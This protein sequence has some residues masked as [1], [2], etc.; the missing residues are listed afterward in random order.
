MRRSFLILALAGALLCSEA[1]A[2]EPEAGAA[3]VR[4]VDVGAGLCC[5]LVLPDDHYIVYDT[6][7]FIDGGETAMAAVE[8]LIPEDEEIDLLVLSHSDADHLAAADEILQAYTVRRVLR[9]GF[10]RNTLAW[11]NAD[12]AARAARYSDE[13]IDINLAYFEYPPGG[14][15]RFGEAFVTFIAGFHTP[16]EDWDIDGNSERRNAGSIVIRLQF[17]GRSALFTG[18]A[19]GRHI[20]G[21]DD[22]LIASERFMVEMSPI[23]GIDSD[24][25]I[26][27]H[28]GADN[29]SAAAF[30]EAVSPE[31]VIFSAG[32]RHEHPRASAAQRYLDFGVPVENIFR[33]DLG[34]DEGGA[35]WPAGRVAG[36]NDPR[37]DDDVDVLIRPDGEII[38]A[39]RDP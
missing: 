23:I 19:V 6:G 7:N 32:H 14:T 21:P 5:V 18:D 12:A 27:P 13:T 30:I 35:E 16:P 1:L 26:A 39:H 25:L 17:A 31:F 8:E 22:Q 29:A 33:T 4:I 36:H 3:F 34:D 37:G 2:L 11:R 28:H 38:V 9:T 10:E 15:Y 24:V 20:G